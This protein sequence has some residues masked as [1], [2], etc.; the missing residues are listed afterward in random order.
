MESALQDFIAANNAAAAPSGTTAS[1]GTTQGKVDAP[2][3][4]FDRVLARETGIS[5]AT[6][7]L[8]P[9]APKLKE[10]QELARTHRI[11]ERL[12]ALE[13]RPLRAAVAPGEH[14]L[15]PRALAVRRGVG[16]VIAVAAIEAL[17]LAGRRSTSHWFDSPVGQ[18][19]SRP[20]RGRCARL[21]SHR[22]GA[23][24]R[25]SRSFS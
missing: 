12:A 2:A 22:Q 15:C 18:D 19:G 10:L 21:A 6:S 9:D 5:G 20:A 24:P 7:P 1:S 14:V 8:N 11:D 16:L 17:A 25:A 23:D 3:A 4:A 13:G